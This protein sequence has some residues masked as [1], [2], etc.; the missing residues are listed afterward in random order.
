MGTP[1]QTEALVSWQLSWRLKILMGMDR[2][3]MWS[4][5]ALIMFC[6]AL[7]VGFALLLP[8]NLK[9]KDTNEPAREETG[10][11]VVL[12]TAFESKEIRVLLLLQVCASGSFHLYD[13]T[14]QLYLQRTLGYTSAQRGYIL[15]FAGWM[16][17]VQT[18]AVVPRLIRRWQASATLLLRISFM[19]IAP[20]VF[21]ILT[22]PA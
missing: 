22:L 9:V 17:A 6:A 7:Q 1:W 18:F 20:P 2:Q 14:A 11:R 5:L 19:C 12:A 15:A 8:S 21:G 16:F 3:G 10:W 4:S 13:A